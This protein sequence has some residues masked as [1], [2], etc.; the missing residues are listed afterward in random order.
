VSE[1]LLDYQPAGI[2][3]Q[4]LD[5]GQIEWPQVRWTHYLIHQRLHYAY[6][7]PVRQLRHRLMVVPAD[8]HG[9]QQLLSHQLQLTPGAARQQERVDDFG[10]RV[11]EFEFPQLESGLTFEVWSRVQQQVQDGAR[12]VVAAASSEHYRQP[13]PLTTADATLAAIAQELRQ[14]YPDS[15]QLAEQINLWTHQAMHYQRGLT[16]VAT[17]AAQAL[18]VGGGL[19]Q[20]FAHIMLAICR[21]AGLAARYVSGHLLGEGAS[22][23]WVEVLLPGSQGH[24]LI[25]WAFDPTNNC[26]AGP[27]YITIAVGRDYADVS[28]TSG[29]F[30]AASP[31]RLVISKRAGLTAVAYSDGRVIK[32]G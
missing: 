21:S 23:A 26:Q 29:S 15:W 22:H 17:T 6:P 14:S 3:T 19:C 18:A 25:A 12:P 31:G 1:P 20:D 28:P 4:F 8:Q 7:G 13:T 32:S 9:R 10:N 24:E 11:F 27:Q 16:T 30:I 5:H 2:P